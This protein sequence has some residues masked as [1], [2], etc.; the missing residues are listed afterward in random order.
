[1]IS[2]GMAAYFCV[3]NYRPGAGEEQKE[4]GVYYYLSVVSEDTL[5]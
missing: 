1:M 4:D 3:A 2:L 5:P